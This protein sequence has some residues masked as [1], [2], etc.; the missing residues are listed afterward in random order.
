MKRV[1]ILSPHADDAVWSLG[2]VIRGWGKRFEVVIVTVFNAVP[3][4]NAINAANTGKHQSWRYLPGSEIRHRED[5]RA[6]AALG[7][8]LDAWPFV[9]AAMRWGANGFGYPAAKSLFGTIRPED[10][11]LTRDVADRLI[12]YLRQDDI[13]V[14]P[15]ALGGHVD[16]QIMRDIAAQLEH[17]VVYYQD[18]PYLAELSDP[19]VDIHRQ[20]IARTLCSYDIGCDIREWQDAAQ[21]Y[22][23]QV[24]RLFG[25]S[26]VFKD[27]L[28]RQSLRYGDQPVCRIWS[29]AST[30]LARDPSAASR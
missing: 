24:K 23:S 26:A 7:A 27:L 5:R 19:Q 18:L 8:K 29:R 9:D 20:K 21:I 3:E 10:T 12:T 14:A 4:Q 13:V 15:L 1:V 6:A 25:R 17:D 16:H 11:P 22:R 2:G 30:N 28:H